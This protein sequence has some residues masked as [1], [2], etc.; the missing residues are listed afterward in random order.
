MDGF[1]FIDKPKGMTSQ[2]VCNRIRKS[3]NIKK[4]GH[5][6]TLDPFATGLLIVSL[7]KATKC[8]MFLSGDDKEYIATLKLGSKTS[9]GDIEGEVIE[10]KEV[11]QC[12][13]EEIKEALNSFLGE[14]YQLPPMTSAIKINGQKLYELAHKGKEID[15]PKRLIK[16]H[17][18]SLISYQDDI[19]VFKAKVSKGTYLRTL[20][21]DIALKLGTVGHLIELRRSKVGPYKIEDSKPLDEISLDDIKSTFDVLK[22]DALVKE[23]DE[24]MI[25]D[26]K[27]GKINYLLED[28]KFD[29]ILVINHSHEVIAM[30]IKEDDKYIFRR[31]LF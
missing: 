30:Y 2:S 19:I 18:I 12:S 9:T 4:V 1:L 16:V 15:R 10:S 21:E 6:G 26:I 31:G 24:E 22:E 20:G 13:I 8:E 23:F 11:K 29:K 25:K 7:N 17:E 27:D 28:S 5:I 3:F 14:S